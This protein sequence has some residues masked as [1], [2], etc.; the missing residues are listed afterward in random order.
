LPEDGS[1]LHAIERMLG[2][3]CEAT[4]HHYATTHIRDLVR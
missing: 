4:G 2:F 3:V 1:L